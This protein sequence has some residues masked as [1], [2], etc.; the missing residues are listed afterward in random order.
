MTS[1]LTNG[2]TLL[3]DLEATPLV[4]VSGIHKVP[5][6]GYYLPPS[7]VGDLTSVKKY[8]NLARVYPGIPPIV[9]LQHVRLER[10]LSSWMSTKKRGILTSY[11]KI[12]F[13]GSSESWPVFLIEMIGILIEY[14][15]Q[16]LLS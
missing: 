12:I 15:L 6:N 5:F 4:L 8:L 3:V 10:Y 7:M 13:N 11:E 9:D 16:E 1:L 2:L 14:G